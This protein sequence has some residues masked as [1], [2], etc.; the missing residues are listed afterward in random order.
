MLLYTNTIAEPEFRDCRA[1]KAFSTVKL[2]VTPLPHLHSASH[3]YI[4]QHETHILI[5][6]VSHL[7]INPFTYLRRQKLST[8]CYR[9]FS[10]MNLVNVC[11]SPCFVSG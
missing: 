8:Q 11:V 4:E 6:D 3:L 9:F 1:L 2:L 5:M 7:F 10:Y